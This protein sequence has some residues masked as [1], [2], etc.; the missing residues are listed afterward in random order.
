MYHCN[1]KWYKY[2][3]QVLYPTPGIP[4]HFTLLIAYFCMGCLFEL[5]LLPHPVKMYLLF[6]QGEKKK[7]GTILHIDAT[8]RE[9]G[10]KRSG[11]SLSVHRPSACFPHQFKNLPPP[12]TTIKLIIYCT[13]FQFPCCRSIFHP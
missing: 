9:V 4:K 13:I 6:S 7:K 10:T 3:F 8:V 2:N 11:N 5:P 1:Q 12:Q